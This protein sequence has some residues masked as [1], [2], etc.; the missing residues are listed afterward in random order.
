MA[1]TKIEMAKL[2]KIADVGAS[3]ASKYLSTMAKKTVKVSIP[4]VAAHPYE[5][6]TETIGKP[7]SG[8]I[9][10]FMT[11]SGDIEGVIV[12]V[13]P[14]KA[15]IEIAGL[16][17]GRRASKSLDDLGRSALMEA[18]G[19]ILA[20][21]YL[22]AFG[23]TLKLNLRDSVPVMAQDMLGS[24][25]DGVLSDFA[26]KSV[27]A[28]IFKNRFTLDGKELSGDACILFDPTSY[29][30]IKKRLAKCTAR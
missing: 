24:I 3:N 8:V 21:A 30:L 25:L 5:Q 28:L 29:P 26:S 7:S 11:M 16:L 20:N 18:C 2:G 4:W 12:M 15:A 17:T 1:F 22:N 10:V 6:I 13:F 27:E 23:D 14:E 9:A 19:N